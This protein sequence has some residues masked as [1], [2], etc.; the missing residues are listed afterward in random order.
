MARSG[1]GQYKRCTITTTGERT[2]TLQVQE[3][4]GS[5]LNAPCHRVGRGALATKGTY[6]RVGKLTRTWTYVLAHMHAC[7]PSAN[8]V[9][10]Q[11]RDVRCL[12]TELSARSDLPS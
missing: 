5:T 11:Y 8:K 2:I 6:R 9:R 3:A 7:P 4:G 1:N 12:A 10:M